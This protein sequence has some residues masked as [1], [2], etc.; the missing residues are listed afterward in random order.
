M[1][2]S[3][4]YS[5]VF[6]FG[7]GKGMNTTQTYKSK[8]LGFHH[9]NTRDRKFSHRSPIRESRF[10]EAAPA[11]ERGWVDKIDVDPEQYRKQ[12]IRYDGCKRRTGEVP[13]EHKDEDVV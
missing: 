12:V 10:G 3:T 5:Q 7:G 6:F 13:I 4:E 8:P 9:Y 11:F 1:Y 2:H